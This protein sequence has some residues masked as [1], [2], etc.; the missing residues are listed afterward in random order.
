MLQLHF[1]QWSTGGTSAIM[2]PYIAVRHQSPQRPTL[3]LIVHRSDEELRCFDERGFLVP[4]ELSVMQIPLSE[5]LSRMAFLSGKVS[6]VGMESLTS[7][8]RRCVCIRHI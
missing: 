8:K 3:G 6:A 4:I 2:C 5:D 7:N 1:H